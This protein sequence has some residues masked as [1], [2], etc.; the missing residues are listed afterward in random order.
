MMLYG[1]LPKSYT[2]L[3]LASYSMTLEGMKPAT[4]AKCSPLGD[5]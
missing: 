4:T 2:G 1:P 3:Q 5:H